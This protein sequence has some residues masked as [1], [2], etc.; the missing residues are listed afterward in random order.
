[1]AEL[2]EFLCRWALDELALLGV[3]VVEELD[4]LDDD[5]VDEDDVDE[6]EDDDEEV[7]PPMWLLFTF[8]FR[9]LRPMLLELCMPV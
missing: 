9:L 6:E 4:E 1:M 8:A 2:R 3:V 7:R 5:E